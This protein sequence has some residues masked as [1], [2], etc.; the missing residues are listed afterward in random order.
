MSSETIICTIRHARTLYNEEKRYAGSLDIPISARGIREARIA[1][2]RLDGREF[3]AVVA[4]TMRRAVE[5]ARLLVPSPVELRLC[6]LCVERCFGALEGLMW[7]QVQALD[8]PIRFIEA[9]GDLHSVDPPG[10]E[11]FEE[12]WERASRFR[13][14]LLRDYATRRVL[15][16][17]HGVFLQMFHGVLRGSTWMDSLCAYPANLALATFCLSDGRLTSENTTRLLDEA[18]ADF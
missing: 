16:V 14:L 10:G 13:D 1:S 4:S 6:N 9:G 8:P 5:T 12:V 3:D 7:E 17:S 18:E 15:V 2:A 11:R